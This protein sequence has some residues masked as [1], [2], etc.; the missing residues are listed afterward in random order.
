MGNGYVN[1]QID[2]AGTKGSVLLIVLGVVAA[3][4]LTG[5]LMLSKYEQNARGARTSG[6]AVESN[7]LFHSIQQSINNEALCSKAFQNSSYSYSCRG[8]KKISGFGA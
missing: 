7:A 6:A 5:S 3:L 8:Y 1:R 2:R 4:A